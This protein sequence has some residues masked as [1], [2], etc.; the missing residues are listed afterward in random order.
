MIKYIETVPGK[1]ILPGTVGTL[2]LHI[3]KLRKR[4]FS[5][6]LFSRYQRNERAFMLSLMEMVIQGV[7]TRKVSKI[8]ETLWKTMFSAQTV[9]NLCKELNTEINEFRNQPLTHDY[10]FIIADATYVRVHSKNYGVI[11]V[12]LFIVLGIREDGV[13]DVLAF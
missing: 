12:G 1:E 4:Y 9:S 10:P 2:N 8:T 3:P 7:S 11:S 13:R 5:T 6:Q